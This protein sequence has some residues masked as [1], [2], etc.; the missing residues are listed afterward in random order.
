[1]AY[2]FDWR[3]ILDVL[4]ICLLIYSVYRALRATGAWKIALGLT[5]AVAVALVSK[6]LGLQ[7]IEWI[8]SNFTQ[9]ALVALLIIFQPEI[10]RI[11]ER[12]FSFHHG[13][14]VGSE[15]QI[16]EILDQALF[17]L[18]EKH[19][20]ALVVFVG[21][22]PIKQ[23]VTEGVNLDAK[24]SLPLLLSLFDPY[25][26]GHDGAAIIEGSRLT[27]FGSH[28]PLSKTNRLSN[29][30]GTRHHAAMGMSERTDSLVF[31]VSEERGVVTAFRDG[32][33][34][35]M[36]SRGDVAQIIYNFVE[37]KE[38][39]KGKRKAGKKYFYTFAEIIASLSL[40]VLIWIAFIQPKTEIREMIYT[41]PIEYER[42]A[43]DMLISG[44]KSEAKLLLQGPLSVLRGLDPSQL[45]VRLDLSSL[46]PGM[47]RISLADAVIVYPS[48]LMLVEVEPDSFELEIRQVNF[49]NVSIQPQLIGSLP[50]GYILSSVEIFPSSVAIEDTV[51]I[52]YLTTT[53]IYM[54]GLRENVT[55]L[56]KII[57]PEKL[58]PQD[59]RWPDVMVRLVI[60]AAKNK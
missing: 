16:P 24:P 18:A 8:F 37:Y 3:I 40:A 25:S 50:N 23:W 15:N 56:C 2:F 51:D 9:V 38:P 42:P 26:P 6:V 20:G 54:N 10:R 11:L 53:P 12:S 33:I 14:R 48:N 31:A 36:K 34:Y 30:Y 21:E 60:S 57:I 4:L 35:T 17:D 13:K 29:E 47:H 45:R 46:T 58:Q 55:V 43:K 7:G 49:R 39:V 22:V 28:L 1:M 27:Q 32:E 59:R 41:V 5:F 19:W 44:K 52:S